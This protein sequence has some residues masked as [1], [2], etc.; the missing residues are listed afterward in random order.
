[1]R[2]KKES[3]VSDQ[4]SLLYH[5]DKTARMYFEHFDIQ[6]ENYRFGLQKNFTNFLTSWK[7]PSHYWDTF[8]YIDTLV[9]RQTLGDITK[10]EVKEINEVFG[11]K[12]YFA[13][14][15][16]NPA[17]LYSFDWTL[18]AF[19]GFSAF[20]ALYGKFI[21]GYSI[22]WLVMPF[23]PCWMAML[24]NHKQQPH[25]ELE[26][27]YNYLI[28][29]RA[30]TAEFQLNKSKVENAFGKYAKQ[31][32]ELKNHLKKKDMTLY[33]LEAQVYA[34]MNSGSLK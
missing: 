34:K 32:E 3:Q 30:A 4:S 15:W 1:M 16:A 11:G 27:A 24:W 6:I 33:D 31:R 28:H 2:V 29:K 8:K 26:N 21:K 12:R 20:Y 7:D 23:A 18:S 9:Q 5:W 22:V 19:W 17:T 25:Q 14:S 10:Q 13:K